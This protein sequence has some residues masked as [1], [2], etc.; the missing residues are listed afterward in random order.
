M[1]GS[2]ANGTSTPKS[3]R[4]IMM[5]EQTSQISSTLSMPVWFSILAMISMSCPPFA[6]RKFRTSSTSCRRETNDAAT[7]SIPFRMP[8]SRSSLSCSLR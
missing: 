5:P 7:K 4:P 2:S 3:P 8:N 6:S 1:A